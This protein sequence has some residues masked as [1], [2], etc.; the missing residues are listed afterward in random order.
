VAD[1]GPVYRGLYI[2]WLGLRECPDSPLEV[3]P[4]DKKLLFLGQLRVSSRV[5]AGAGEARDPGDLLIDALQLVSESVELAGR[6]R[7]CG[8]LR[9]RRGRRPGLRRRAGRGLTRFG[10][11]VLDLLSI[12]RDARS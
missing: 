7:R 11:V 6:G 1:V 8:G 10:G 12:G 2:H 4:L 5:R 9:L 3:L